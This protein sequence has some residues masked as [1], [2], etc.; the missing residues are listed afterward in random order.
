L[1][2]NTIRMQSRRM[3][4][5]RRIWGAAILAL[6]CI[7]QLTSL[8]FT[9]MLSK[10]ALTG[11]GALV[12]E[13]RAANQQV[14]PRQRLTARSAGGGFLPLGAIEPAITSYVE[15]W[16]PYFQFAKEFG[17]APEFLLHWGHGVAM[18]TVLFAMV[19]Y[20]AFLGWATRFGNGD[21][22]Y[23]LNLGYSARELHSLLMALALFFFFL[24]G[25]GG[26]VLLATQFKPILQ[27]AHSSTAVLGLTCM[28][29]Q[30]VLGKTMGSSEGLRTLHAVFGTGTILLLVAHAYFGFDLGQS[31]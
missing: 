6:A 2:R 22:V 18:G 8:A 12:H 9:S 19:G 20:G 10:A 13:S 17:L 29:A 25:Q 4:V 23:P 11:G 14:R 30:A 31:F 21:A 27:S 26:L 5:Q 28:G 15:I 7:A 16:T 3:K 1:Q 24:G